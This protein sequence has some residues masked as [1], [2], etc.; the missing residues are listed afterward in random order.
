MKEIK[1]NDTSAGCALLGSLF[2]NIF[3]W[4]PCILVPSFKCPLSPWRSCRFLFVWEC[5]ENCSS[6][7]RKRWHSSLSGRSH[8]GSEKEKVSSIHLHM[9]SWGFFPP[10]FG[11]MCWISQ[12]MRAPA[13]GHATY[14]PSY[15]EGESP[16]VNRTTQL[17]VRGRAERVILPLLMSKCSGY[18]WLFSVI[19]RALAFLLGRTGLLSSSWAEAK[20]P[21]QK[22]TW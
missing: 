11:K 7:G 14:V 21:Y 10:W 19:P 13:A 22:I 15:P 6:K 20:G 4:F 9:E 18:F 1:P 8:Q 3:L 17:P 12:P 2:P 5:C 16:S